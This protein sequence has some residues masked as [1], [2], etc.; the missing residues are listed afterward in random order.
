[1]VFLHTQLLFHF[2][3]SELEIVKGINASSSTPET[4]AT[5]KSGVSDVGFIV[6]N[7]LLSSK[8]VS[9]NLQIYC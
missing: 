2:G 3:L 1:M 7:I 4:L 8:A 9:G 5:D 6:T